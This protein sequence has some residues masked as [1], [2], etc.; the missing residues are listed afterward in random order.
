HIGNDHVHIIWNESNH[1]YRP[2][3]ISGDFGNVQIQIRPLEPGEYGIGIYH[4]SRLKPF[5]PLTNGMVVSAS[6]LPDAARATAING[7][8]RVLQTL[9]KAYTHPFVIR[10]EMINRIEGE[11]G[12]TVYDMLTNTLSVVGVEG[13]G[14]ADSSLNAVINQATP[15]AVLYPKSG[16]AADAT[17]LALSEAVDEDE[18]DFVL[19]QHRIAQTTT[20]AAGSA[21]TQPSEEGI[22]GQDYMHSYRASVGCAGAIIG[23]LEAQRKCDLARIVVVAWRIYLQVFDERRH[24]NMHSQGKYHE[25]MSLFTLMDRTKS[26]AGREMLRR[27]VLCPLQTLPEITERLDATELHLTDMEALAQFAHAIVK[28]HQLVASMGSVP[29]LLRELLALD[30][31]VFAELGCMIIDTVDFDTSRT[32]ERVVVA[33]CVNS[34]VDYL[35]DRFERLDDVLDVASA[36]MEQAAGVPVIAVYFP[37][38]GFLSSIDTSRFLCTPGAEPRLDGW[39]LRFQT[40]KQRYYKNR[41]TKA[42]DESPGDVFSQLHD[43]EAEVLVELQGRISARRLEIVRA[44]ELAARIDW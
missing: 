29:K 7:H 1:N 31:S 43:A 3:T 34:Q 42:L 10:Q 19:G 16:S 4:E 26:A 22:I 15:D 33:P 25:A 24:P 17:K 5:G 14:S 2:E 27:W 13:G 39:V 8:R 12:A 37:Q 41:I 44:A 11:F 6:A 21:G 32:E 35:R 18:F 40:D 36:D 23:Y 9:V 30:Q 28:L 20:A 38:L